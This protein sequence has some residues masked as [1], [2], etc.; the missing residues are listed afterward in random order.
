MGTNEKCPGYQPRLP[1]KRLG[2]PQK[3]FRMSQMRNATFRISR[4]GNE[5]FPCFCF[6]VSSELM[7]QIKQKGVYGVEL[8]LMFHMS[9]EPIITQH[10][11]VC[12]CVCFLVF[13]YECIIV[14]ACVF[15]PIFN[16]P[17]I[18]EPI[19]H[20]P[21]VIRTNNNRTQNCVGLCV[22]SCVLV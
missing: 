16:V 12:V 19:F 17:Y 13:G 6:S 14:C 22:F 10:K 2:L 4:M 11:I 8:Y 1:Q 15:E 5:T 18:Y 7:V 21:Y 20:V 9:Y 3:A